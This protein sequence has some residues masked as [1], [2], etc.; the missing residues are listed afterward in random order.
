MAKKG[1]RSSGG[2]AAR[3]RNKNQEMAAMMKKLNTRRTHCNCPICHRP[4]R[5]PFNNWDHHRCC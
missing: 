4:V 2:G 5:L 1:A 3:N